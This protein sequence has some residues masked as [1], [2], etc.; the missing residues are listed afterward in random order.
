M[1]FLTNFEKKFHVLAQKHP[2]PT[3]PFIYRDETETCYQNES[4]CH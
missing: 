2:T 3:S 1:H 4:I